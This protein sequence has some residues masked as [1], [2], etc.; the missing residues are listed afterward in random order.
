MGRGGRAGGESAGGQEGGARR[1]A[2]FHAE[3][4]GQSGVYVLETGAMGRGGRSGGDSAGG[5]QG[6]A[7]RAAPSHAEGDGQSGGNKREPSVI[8]SYDHI[9]SLRCIYFSNL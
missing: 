6:G 1:A 2:S 4:D 9:K 3:G 5:Q 8:T 7:R